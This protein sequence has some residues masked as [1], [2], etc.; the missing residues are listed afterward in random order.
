MP[1]IELHA[2]DAGKAQC[3]EHH[4]LDFEITLDT[5]MPVDFG[6]DL[7]R[8]ARTIDAGRQGVQHTAGITQAIDAAPVH[9]VGID[10]RHLRRD[11]GAQ[12]HGAA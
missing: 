9:Q 1:D 11:V 8:L 2:V 3:I 5:G 7:Q 12:A 6:A 10:P 4:A